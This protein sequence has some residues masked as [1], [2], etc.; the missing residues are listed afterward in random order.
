VFEV[1]IDK[2]GAGT[3]GRRALLTA[4]KSPGAWIRWSVAV[5]ESQGRLGPVAAEE[6]GRIIFQASES[7]VYLN[8][9]RQVV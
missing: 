5:L 7:R 8:K 3:A 4:P 9:E 6:S 2:S 1:P